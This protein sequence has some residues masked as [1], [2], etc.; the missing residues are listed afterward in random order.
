[1]QELFKWHER[2]G[3]SLLSELSP[4]PCWPIWLLR[5]ASGAGAFMEAGLAAEVASVG[6]DST[7]AEAASAAVDLEEV[8]LEE[9]DFTEVD[10]TEV[11]SGA[12]W[13]EDLPM[14]W[15]DPEVDSDRQRR[16]TRRSAGSLIR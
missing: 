16:L 8:D 6:A 2:T 4:V 13:A 10:F 14:E 12:V 5:A 7:Q 15:E 9:V 3:S 1:M 11:D